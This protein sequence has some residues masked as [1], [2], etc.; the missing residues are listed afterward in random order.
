MPRKIIL[1]RSLIAADSV[2]EAM[3]VAAK[4]AV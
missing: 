1:L 4:V 3:M 2:P